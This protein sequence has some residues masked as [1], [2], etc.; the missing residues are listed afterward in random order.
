MGEQY[1]FQTSLDV[2]G[3]DNARWNISRLSFESVNSQP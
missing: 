3:K 1:L 2:T